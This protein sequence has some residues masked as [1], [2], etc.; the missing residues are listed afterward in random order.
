MKTSIEKINMLPSLDIKLGLV[1]S[2]DFHLHTNWTAGKYSVAEMYNPAVDLGVQAV[3][4]SEHG[5]KTSTDWFA[6]FAADVRRLPESPCR[7]YVGVECKIESFEGDIDTLPEITELCD[8]VMASV[9]RFPDKNSGSLDFDK[10][11]SEKAIELEFQ[12]SWA[13]LA[14]PIVDI[15]GHPFGMSYRRFRT[16]PSEEK[17]LRL[18]ERAAEYNVAF[19]VNSYY[20]PDP[21]R[22]VKLCREAGARITLGSNSH[23]VD[24]V[25]EVISVLK[26]RMPVWNPFEFS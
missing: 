23:S 16:A 25:G 15:L 3:L 6:G 7:A 19:E 20:H 18:I 13:A 17:I 26:R 11:S 22:M 1:P 9:H 2:M 12:L 21:W 10:V 5:R 24:E 8:L 4:F 14:N